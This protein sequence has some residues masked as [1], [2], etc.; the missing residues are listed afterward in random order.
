[1]Y[2]FCYFFYSALLADIKEMSEKNQTEDE[3]VLS[4]IAAA[5]TQPTKPDMEFDY[6]DL[7]IQDDIYQLVKYSCKEVCTPEQRDKVMKI[8][9]AFIEPLLCV[10]S[11][12]PSAEDEKYVVKANNHTKQNLN[13]IGPENRSTAD[14][15]AYYEPAEI[16]KGGQPENSFCSGVQDTHNTNG[17]ISDDSHGA[18]KFASKS[19]I[20]CKASPVSLQENDMNV[21]TLKGE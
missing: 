13:Q 18:Y 2:F 12:P 15:V 11:R 3:M 6:P 17:D 14:E 21:E 1:M 10:P 5:Y 20:L 16:S 19:G 4:I 8:W 7:D 9:T